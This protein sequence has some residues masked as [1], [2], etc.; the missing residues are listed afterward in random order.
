[1]RCPSTGALIRFSE[2]AHFGCTGE[3]AREMFPFKQYSAP[4]IPFSSPG[5]L[6]GGSDNLKGSYLDSVGLHFLNAE[7][8]SLE[9]T[10][11][12]CVPCLPG[13]TS[14]CGAGPPTSKLPPSLSPLCPGDS[15]PMKTPSPGYFSS[16][17]TN[18][19]GVLESGRLAGGRSSQKVSEPQLCGLLPLPSPALPRRDNVLLQYSHV[20]GLWQLCP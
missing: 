8:R 14:S 6:G 18:R 16:F 11:P 13:N 10:S 20:S 15:A 2:S 1:M 5:G 19:E 17:E 7:A 4:F 3:A 9:K 12:V